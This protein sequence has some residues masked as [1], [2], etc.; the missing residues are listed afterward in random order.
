MTPQQKRAFVRYRMRPIGSKPA[1]P[2]EA[3]AVAAAA[4]AAAKAAMRLELAKAAGQYVL[5]AR[6]AGRVSVTAAK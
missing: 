6:A 3:A 4:G 5:K 1:S 2:L